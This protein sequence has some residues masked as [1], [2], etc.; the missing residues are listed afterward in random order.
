MEGAKEHKKGKVNLQ[1]Q[2][3]ISKL[4]DFLDKN[5]KKFRTV[6][7]FYCKKKNQGKKRRSENNNK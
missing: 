1:G 5:K 6:D 4:Q 3:T 7:K 2:V